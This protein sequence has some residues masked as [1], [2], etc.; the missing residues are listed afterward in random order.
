MAAIAA[1]IDNALQSAESEQAGLSRRL[2][3]V[4]LSATMIVA[5]V[6]T[7]TLIARRLIAR[8]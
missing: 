1:A 3:E 8:G 7:I 4:R 6:T 5:M 2:E